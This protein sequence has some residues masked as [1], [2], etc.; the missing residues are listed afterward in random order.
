[1]PEPKE[2]PPLAG[3][4]LPNVS[5]HVP[6]SVVEYLNHPVVDPPFGFAKPFKVAVV[7]VGVAGFVMTWGTGIYTLTALVLAAEDPPTPKQEMVNVL[8]A[9]VAEV[10]VMDLEWLPVVISAPVNVPFQD[11]AVMDGAPE[12]ETAQLVAE[13]VIFQVKLVDSPVAIVAGVAVKLTS[14]AGMQFMMALVS[15]WKL[16]RANFQPGKAKGLTATTAYLYL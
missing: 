3:T 12:F 10:M 11:P 16:F 15:V 2:A 14:G 6:G 9:A 1:M 5:L 13:P 8:S 4:L 7:I